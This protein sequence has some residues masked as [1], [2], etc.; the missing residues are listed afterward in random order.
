MI[1]T[2]LQDSINIGL[3]E[4]DFWDMTFAEIQR[5]A[6]GVNYRREQEIK[7][8]AQMDYNL[9]A[10][11]GQFVSCMFSSSS[12]PPE[13]YDIYPS[14]FEREDQSAN[15]FLKF[16]EEFNAKFTEGDNK[17]NE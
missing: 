4:Q 16:A 5:Y 13:I 17:N 12:K 10:T 7:L 11:I 1:D 9:A 3:P 8:R 6:N 14:L 15:N 2:I